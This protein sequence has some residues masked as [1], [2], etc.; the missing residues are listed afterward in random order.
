MVVIVAKL[1]RCQLGKAQ[2]KVGK[3]VASVQTSKGEGPAG[4]A[5]R[6]GVDLDPPEITAPAPGVL[7][8]PVDQVVGKSPGLIAQQ[9]RAGIVQA[10]EVSE[11]QVG[12]TPVER[13][14]RNTRD[15]EV[16]GDVLVK[17]VK[18]LCAG[19]GAIEVETR[20]VDHLAKGSYVSDGYVEAAGMGV[21]SDAGE[22]IGQVRAG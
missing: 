15:A 11:R 5:V 20:V 13:V 21:A 18:V 10:A 22:R 4:V 19:P 12:Q 17:G 16:S 6:V 8:A 14:G 7:S 2:Q 9:L 1:Y 3:V